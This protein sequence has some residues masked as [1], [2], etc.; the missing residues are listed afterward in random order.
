[1]LE[2]H[3]ESWWPHLKEVDFS[4][5]IKRIDEDEKKYGKLFPSKKNIFR[6]FRATPYENT[7]L[8]IL[9]QDPYPSS[10]AMG[11]AFGVEDVPIPR[12]LN[13]IHR[14]LSRSGFPIPAL[15]FKEWTDVGILMLNAA[16]TNC[17]EIGQHLE[18]WKH[19]TQKVLEVAPTKK[20]IMMGK[21]AQSFGEGIHV[22]HPSSEFYNKGFIGSNAFDNDY[23]RNIW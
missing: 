17:G 19:F 22:P 23:F 14:E 13:Y 8:I 11:I 12:S 4:S 9:G 16:L 15:D 5:I 21:V 7:K 18:L 20:I 1:M 2:R 3:L 10:Q 6:A